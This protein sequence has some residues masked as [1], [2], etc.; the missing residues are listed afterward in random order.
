MTPQNRC[1]TALPLR[2]SGSDDEHRTA[3]GAQEE[4]SRNA[5]DQI[6]LD[7]RARQIAAA[8]RDRFDRAEVERK[9]G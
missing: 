6:H 4:R 9:G 3:T 2:R 5:S 1:C 8:A 7:D